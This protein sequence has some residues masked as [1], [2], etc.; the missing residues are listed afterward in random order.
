MSPV[1][2]WYL[3]TRLHARGLKLPAKLIKL[4]IYL[5][6]HAVLPS[7]AQ[8]ERDIHLEH[9]G[10]GVVVHPNV[11][12]G[13]GVRIYQHVTI[14]TRTW[15]GSP[16]RIVIEDNVLLGA[17]CVLISPPDETMVIGSGTSVGA[18][19]VVTKAVPPNSIMV[20]VPAKALDTR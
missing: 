1:R 14:A 12:L 20:G 4:L 13:H 18:N 15:V 3:S 9:Y 2:L 10:L 7:E 11:T 5:V 16:A 17:G 6:Y 8:I 19:A